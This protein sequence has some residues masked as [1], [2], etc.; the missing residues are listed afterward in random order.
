MK[1]VYVIDSLQR[2]GTQRFLTHLA[3]GLS[4]FGYEQTIIAL[5]SVSDSSVVS[6]L[7]STHCE[8]RFIG[9]FAL[10]LGGLGWWRLVYILRRSNPDIVLTMLDF[11]DTLGRP[12]AKIAGCRTIVTSIR[13]R[14]LAKPRWRRWID[15]KTV[16]W[17]QKV[18]F[19][20]E[21]VVTFGREKEGVRAE[22]VAVIHNG[23]ED[24]HER[25]AFFRDDYRSKLS[26]GAETQLLG[27]V[28]RLVRQKN[29]ALL[30]RAAAKL[31]TAKQWKLLVVGDGPEKNRLR[32]LSHD[33][34][35]DD[36]LIWLGQRIDV[37][38]WMA[39]MDLFVHTADFE[40]M[41][42][43]VMEAMSMGLPVVASAADGNRELIRH[44]ISGYLVAPGDADAFAKRIDEIIEDRDLARR[45]GEQAQRDILERFGLRQMIDG[46]DGLFASLAK[47]GAV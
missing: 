29:L 23:V 21:Y 46:Y 26:I 2:H 34:G 38:G 41:P 17:A 28:G 47:S 32:S 16:R 43:A 25:N 8:V 31:S 33:L 9:K 42:N 37:G 10:L 11:A 20:S 45:L 24:L 12:A 13:A 40:G 6:D 3:R 18:I 36:R 39:A 5:N 22:Q 30:L 27:A 44:G 1:I 19:N 14:N 4:E 7:L 15:R 35:L